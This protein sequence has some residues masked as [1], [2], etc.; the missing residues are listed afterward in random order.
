[1]NK[2]TLPAITAALVVWAA[3]IAPAVSQNQPASEPSGSP[4][5]NRTTEQ[6]GGS[7]AFGTAQRTGR[8]V[9]ADEVRD[10]LTQLGYSNISELRQAH[11]GW[12]ANATKDGRAVALTFNPHTGVVSY[13]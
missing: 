7:S 3:Q 9:S 8:F 11:N 12:E 1:M 5:P 2:P 4:E 13:R 10:R 6:S